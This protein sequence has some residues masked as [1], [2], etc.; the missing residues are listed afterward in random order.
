MTPDSNLHLRGTADYPLTA[1]AALLSA[2]TPRRPPL[3]TEYPFSQESFL[4]KPQ[5]DQRSIPINSH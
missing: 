4:N 5:A 1:T 3:K 2:L